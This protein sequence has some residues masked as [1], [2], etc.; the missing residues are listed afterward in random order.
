MNTEKA[1]NN[2]CEYSRDLQH[3][4]SRYN[5][6][7]YLHMDIIKTFMDKNPYKPIP[8]E[9]IEALT[10][11]LERQKYNAERLERNEY[12]LLLA[13]S[14]EGKAQKEFMEAIQ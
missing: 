2:L 9:L 11:A 10:K 4:A 13:W 6:T 1:I 7:I 12:R 14:L 5:E 3:N 8:D